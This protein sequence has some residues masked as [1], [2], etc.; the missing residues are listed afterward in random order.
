MASDDVLIAVGG[1]EREEFSEGKVV[2][3]DESVSEIQ[4]IMAHGEVFEPSETLRL[5]EKGIK[6]V[7]CG[8]S[9]G[10]KWLA[11]V[12]RPDEAS[13]EMLL[14]LKRVAQRVFVGRSEVGF[15]VATPLVERNFTRCNQF[16]ATPA[17]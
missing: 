17:Q 10:E 3:D 5:H 13:L 8:I 12:L 4:S 9:V 15:A 2:V 7:A 1:T 16:V 14:A 11:S 6:I